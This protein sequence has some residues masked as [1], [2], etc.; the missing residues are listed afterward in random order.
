ME[1][2]I[3]L[4]PGDKGTKRILHTYGDSLMKNM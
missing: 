4:R 1:V 3:V 2:G